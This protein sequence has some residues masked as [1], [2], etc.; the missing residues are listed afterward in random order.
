MIIK[1]ILWLLSSRHLA[2]EENP[3][4]FN[5]EKDYSKIDA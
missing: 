2:S 5:V 4:P 1:H 3:N